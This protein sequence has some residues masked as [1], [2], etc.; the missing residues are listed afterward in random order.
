MNFFSN[1][2]TAS[3]SSIPRST[4]C[5]TSVSSCSFTMARSTMT[6]RRTP[7]V[8]LGLRVVWL[9]ARS[10]I[11]WAAGDPLVSFAIAR[12]RGCHHFRG[13]CWRGWLLVPA[14]ALEIIPHVL[15]IERGLRAPGLVFIGGP[16]ARGIGRERFVDPDQF[17][18]G[19]ESEFEFR[20]G[21]D[22][23]A[24]GGV[25]GGAFVDF[26]GYIAKA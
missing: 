21:N 24:G 8:G 5:P 3:S 14:D 16:E 19:T 9:D 20:V 25:G 18:A 12:A 7:C 1:S 11:E 4:I 17:L 26:Y 6:L 15:L 13:Q 23:A 2:T 10:S 22:D